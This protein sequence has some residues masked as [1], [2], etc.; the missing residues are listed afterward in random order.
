[1]TLPIVNYAEARERIHTGDIALYDGDGVANEI[2]E[3][4][5]GA[6]YGIRASH[7]GFLLWPGSADVLLTVE[8]WSRESR[9]VEFGG[10]V[11][12][13]SGRVHVF[14]LKTGL[15]AQVNM[16][17]AAEFAWRATPVNY[18]ED[19][20]LKA[21]W[22]IISGKPI[23]TVLNSDSPKAVRQCSEL[24]AAIF[25]IAGLPP[26]S[27]PKDLDCMNWPV[28]WSNPALVDGLF[29]LTFP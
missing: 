26:Q 19:H 15:L 17:K 8:A 28:D 4:A 1:M 7:A 29:T 16:D 3:Q 5:T 11:E 2:I 20:L 9:C 21:A 25:R 6:P 22:A 18:P 23:R 27:P 12:Q 13:A 10:R 14:R 24:V